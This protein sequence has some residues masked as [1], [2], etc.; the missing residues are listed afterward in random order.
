MNFKDRLL[1]HFFKINLNNTDDR[2]AWYL[3]VELFWAAIL[4]SVATFN[5]AYA[6]RLG[7]DNFQVSL[8]SSAPALLAALVSFPAGKFFERRSKRKPWIMGSLL[9]YRAGFLLVAA[10][11]WLGFIDVQPGLLAVLILI[12]IGPPAHFFNVGW[13]AM[14]GE[15][16]PEGKRAAVFAARNIVNQVTVAV[17]VF[18]CG[19][20]LTR[21][22]FPINYQSLYVVGFLASMVSS[23]Y[24]YKL[25]VP[26]SLAIP[27]VPP[28]KRRRPVS[29]L[30]RSARATFADHPAFTRITV[31]TFLHGLGVWMA[32]P[33][34]TLYYVRQLDASESWLG[35]NGT[36]ASI[37]TIAGF[38]LWRWLIGKWGE[39]VSLKRTIALVGLYPVLV[40]L[41]PSLPVIL[42]YGVL[43]GLIVP[44]V[45]LSHFNLLL[46]VTPPDARPT[47]TA[48]YVTIMNIG[49]FVAPLISVA[50]ADTIGLAPTLVVA[51]LLSMIGSTSFWWRPVVEK[52]HEYP[53][54]TEPA[55]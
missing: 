39:P 28:E 7:A 25:H 42:L 30:L 17:V 33:L 31:N 13:I 26:D 22:T 2:N 47:Y 43:N 34:Y 10:V 24:L 38:S 23:A 3:V 53:Q 44:G 1:W 52:E 45:N 49:A 21:I 32:G 29:E 11:P 4:G 12:L 9:I 50:I 8:L 5:A 16:I 27:R 37:G 15:T 20:W 35:L 18:L 40:G 54:V 48:I 6:I 36:I 14:L 46:K 19:L 55:A 51:G 41:T